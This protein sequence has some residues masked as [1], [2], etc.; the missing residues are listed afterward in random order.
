MFAQARPTTNLGVLNYS[1]NHIVERIASEG[2]MSKDEAAE[3]F[4]DTLRF[5]AL[6]ATTRVCPPHRVDFSWHIFLLHTKDYAEFCEKHIGFFVHHEPGENVEGS[7]PAMD[8]TIAL[9]KNVYGELSGNWT[10]GKRGKTCG[11]GGC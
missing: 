4:Q 3:V 7:S 2:T 8:A 11:S 5:L 10:P 1:N 6:S 9:A